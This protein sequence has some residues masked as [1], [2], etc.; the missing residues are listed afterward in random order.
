[1]VESFGVALSFTL[2]YVPISTLFALFAALLIDRV[3]AAFPAA[4]L[5]TLY[6]IPVVLPAGIL[7]IAWQ[8]IFDPTWGPLNHI[9][10][11]ILKI[12]WPYTKWLS[13]SRSGAPLRS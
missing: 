4:V 1:M 5:R 9:I 12:P 8:W 7:Y 2:M 13:R 11:D 6:Y 3:R 10:I